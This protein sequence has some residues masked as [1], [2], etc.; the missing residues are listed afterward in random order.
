M[1]RCRQAQ[2]ASGLGHTSLYDAIGK[3][4]FPRPVRIAARSVAWP[5]SEVAA[6]N[7]ARIAGRS[8]EYIRDLVKQLEHARA[9]VD[10]DV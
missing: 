4:L 2:A 3:G 8:D 1:L 10:A 5:D 6:V 9:T 7:A